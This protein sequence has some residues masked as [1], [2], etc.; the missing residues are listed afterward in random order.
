MEPEKQAPDTSAPAPEPTPTP[1]PSLPVQPSSSASAAIDPLFKR[2][3]LPIAIVVSL[4]ILLG[5]GYYFYTQQTGS[6]VFE[7]LFKRDV[8]A[9]VNGKRIYQKELDESVALM[10]QSATMQGIDVSEESVRT[11]IRNQALGVLVNN[12][13]LITAAE[14]AG[15]EASAEEIETTYGELVEQIGGQEALTARMTEVGLTEDKLR[16]NIKERILADQYIE[17]ATD[18][19]NLNVTDEEV[20]QF[21]ASLGTQGTEL[22]P[23]EE[24]RPQIEA[25]ILSGKQQQL[26]AALIEELRAKATIELKI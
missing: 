24:I 14:G 25:Q 18:I 22:P 7:S 21:V 16:N 15:F 10:E 2:Y 3:A 19:E 23:L 12:A 20:A 1:E 9:T 26:V 8:V 5:A 13:L 6:T 4:V 17:S 11:E